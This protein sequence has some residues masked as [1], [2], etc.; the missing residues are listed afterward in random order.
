MLRVAKTSWENPSFRFSAIIEP[1]SDAP[2]PIMSL[3][4]PRRR[5]HQ[6]ADVPRELLALA[7]LNH[8][9]PTGFTDAIYVL[10]PIWQTEFALS[11]S[12]LAIF[13]GLYSGAMASLQIQRGDLPNID[14]KIILCCGTALSAL[15]YALAGLSGRIVGLSFALALAGA[16]SAPS[17]RLR[18]RRF[19]APTATRRA[20]RWRLQFHRRSREGGCPALLS[21]LLVSVTWQQA[22]ICACGCWPCGDHRL[23]FVDACCR[24]GT[25]SRVNYRPKSVRPWPRRLLLCLRS[26]CSTVPSEWGFSPSCHFL[27]IGKRSDASH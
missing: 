19:R 16:G 1:A 26:E 22:V 11:Y 15:G 14:A 2:W 18:P 4:I 17:T 8:A 20:G 25:G 24:Q 5:L 12:V 3:S 27:L 9:L 6:N 23:G 13:R 7:G 10:L 21:L